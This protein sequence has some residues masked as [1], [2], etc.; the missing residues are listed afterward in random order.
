MHEDGQEM[1]DELRE[2]TVPSVPSLYPQLTLNQAKKQTLSLPST[3][4]YYR[5]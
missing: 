3:P 1:T 5:N 2:M 4:L